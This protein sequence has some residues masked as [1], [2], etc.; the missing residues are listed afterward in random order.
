M[1][2]YSFIGGRLNFSENENGW[3][4]IAFELNGEL[5][6]G[7]DPRQRFEFE[8]K[9]NVLIVRRFVKGPLVIESVSDGL[10]DG[11]TIRVGGQ[12]EYSLCYMHTSNMRT[13]K[14]PASRPEY[15]L[16]RP[17]PYQ[18]VRFNDGEANDF[19]AFA[20]F[21]S[22]YRTVLI[23]GDLDQTVFRRNWVLGMDKG[24]RNCI[25]TC[26]AEE[27]Y[28]AS[29]ERPHIK[30]GEEM[31]ISYAYY[32]IRHDIH[33]QYA[34][35]NYIE[36]LNRLW[37]FRGETTRIR[38][39]AVFCTWNYGTLHRISEALILKRAAA[40]RQRIPECT[41]FLIDDGYQ[42]GRDETRYAGLEA[43]YPDPKK[44]YSE[45]LFPAGMTALSENLRAIGLIPCIWLAPT[46][47]LGSR[48]AV[49]HPDW[50]LRDKDGKVDLLPTATYLDIS[51]PEA[52]EFFLTVLDTLFVH[53][54][55]RGLKLDYVT[56][57]FQLERACFRHGSGCEWRDRVYGEIRRRIGEDGFFMTCI[58][59][60][61]GNPF[62]GRFADCYRCGCDIHEGTRQEQLR[63]CLATLPQILLPGRKLFLTN[64]DSMGFGNVPEH[65]QRFRLIWCFI[66]QGI[67]ELGGSIE[68][69]P[70]TQI[71]LWRK[72]LARADRGLRVECP[73]ENAFYGKGLPA[74]LTSGKYMAFFNW[75]ETR[76]AVFKLDL[77]EKPIEVFSGKAITETYWELP[78]FSAALF[79]KQ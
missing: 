22:N 36:E 76:E 67:F 73:D 28:P 50:L 18:P 24:S 39:G 52:W 61:M 6:N 12:S 38:H 42:F 10:L 68:S 25:N 53:W 29:A 55:F 31:I 19:P 65:E 63:A 9:D 70:D 79:Q 54:K 71:Q 78:P 59:M 64:M 44:G 30:A 5:Y 47:R 62:P 77:S 13:E 3:F 69:M 33:P 2:N 35:D 11:G 23:E 16:I 37:H 40:L 15:P 21:D 1:G 49:E 27:Q 26:H 46:V 43:F 75:S 4:G 8:H 20:L 14:F 51:Q 57:W 41:H 32:E 17:V 7:N 60:S 48:L 74:I 56:Q 58:A 72:L 66:T 45:E 34:Y